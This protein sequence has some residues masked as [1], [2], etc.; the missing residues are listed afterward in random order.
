MILN[1]LGN[2]SKLAEQICQYFPP[3]RAY[4]ELFFG[5]GGMFFNKSP[6]SKYN[7]LNDVDDDVYNLFRQLLDNKDELVYWL[8]RAPMSETQFFE[9]SKGK[10]EETPVLNAVRFLVLS[11]YGLYGKKSTM[12]HGMVNPRNQMLKVMDETFEAMKD[13]HFMNVD[14]RKVLARIDYRGD[15][16]SKDAFFCYCDPPYLDTDDNYSHSF[17]EQDSMDLFNLLQESEL[18]WAMSEF[19]Q[20]FILE[21]AQIRGLNVHF[22]GERKNLKNTRTEV[23]ITNYIV[24]QLKLF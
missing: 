9:W 14:F 5:A 16:D 12:R 10:R 3:H 19:D 1:R 7:F 21:Q 18:R 2:K 20:P 11:N 17:T 8:E 24:P 22:L 15:Q 6:R 13:A 4:I 23:L